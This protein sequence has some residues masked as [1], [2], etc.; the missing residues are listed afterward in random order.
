MTSQLVTVETLQSFLD[1][2]NRHDLDAIMEFFAGDCAFFLPR[3]P[4]PWGRRFE[5]VG[6]LEFEGGKIARK[7]SYWKRVE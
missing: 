4:E 5:G 3:G 2:F 7:D 6:L 1:A